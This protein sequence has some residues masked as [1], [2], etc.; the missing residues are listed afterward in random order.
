MESHFFKIINEICKEEK[1]QITNLSNDWILCLEKNGKTR[2]ISGYKFDC[3]PHALGLIMDDKYALYEVLKHKNIPVIEHNIVYK[4][5][6]KCDYAIGFNTDEYVENL[7]NKYNN[8]VILKPNAGTCGHSV[9][10]IK[11]IGELKEHL[12]FLFNSNFS[13]SI[14]PNYNIKSEYRIIMLNGKFHLIYKKVNPF[15]IGDGKKTIK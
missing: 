9:Y 10:N 4:K 7:F 3:N 12:D 6:N 5:D 15:V 8:N 13:V 2:F 1:I 14:C 11:K